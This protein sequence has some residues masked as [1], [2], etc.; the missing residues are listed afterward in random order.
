MITSPDT[1]EMA[2]IVFP[3]PQAFLPIPGGMQFKDVAPMIAG[4]VDNGVGFDDPRVLV[5]LNEATKIIMDYMIPVGG[6]MVCNITAI[7]RFLVL[8][9]NMENIIEAH[10]LTPAD[11][12]AAYNKKDTTQVWYEIVSQ[13]A[14]LDPASAMDNPLLDFGLNGN[15]EDPEDVRRIYFYPGLNPANAVIQVTGA[16]RYLPLKG[17]EDYLIIQNIEAIKCII[18]SIERYENNSPDEAQKYRQSGMDILQAEVKK[19][20][21]DPRN[22]MHR[23]SGY[24]EDI[25][26]FRENTLGWVRAQIALDLPEALRMSKRDLTWTIQQ[27]ERRLMERGIW[28]DTVVTIHGTVLGGLLY[29]PTSVESVLAV[30][31]CG[32][33]IPIR[34]QFFQFLEN[35]PGGAPGCSMLIDQGNKLQPGFNAPR[36]AYKLIAS[37]DVG[38]SFTAVCKLKWV[39]KEPGDLMVIRNYEALRLMVSAKM[40]EENPNPQIAQLAQVDQQQALD[41]LD[42][43]LKNYL[44]GIRHT[45]HIQTYGFGLGDVGGYGS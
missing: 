11:S 12:T 39:L 45:V 38:T 30:D 9:P 22:Y 29:M 3:P 27:A 31:L 16:K 41:I 5:R 25:V 18:L 13:S 32:R 21:F 40:K 35:G 4:I 17:D 24:L 33:P 8:P 2:D 43:E 20:L 42:K 26:N 36:R 44:S 19:H 7:S 28:K 23:K 1:A 14:Y 15:P 37:C 10:P 6:M 34:S